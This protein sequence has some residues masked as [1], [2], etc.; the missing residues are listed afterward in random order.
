MLLHPV[1][2]DDLVAV[3]TCTGSLAATTQDRLQALHWQVQTLAPLHDIDEPADL[4]YLPTA[5]TNNLSLT[6]GFRLTSS[7]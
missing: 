2:A 5:L 4:Q 7:T 3:E 6:Q 1:Q